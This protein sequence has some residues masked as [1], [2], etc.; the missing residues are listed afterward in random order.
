MNDP[1][2]DDPIATAASHVQ[3]KHD[4]EVAGSG[5]GEEEEEKNYLLPV[6]WWWT[7][8]AFPLIAGT[9]GPIANAFSICALGENW[10]VKI[11]QGG[12]KEHG[13]DIPAPKW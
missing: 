6:R 10:L 9:F 1:G 8:T 4:N 7:S 12:T 5:V 13:I 2:L 3:E 11:P